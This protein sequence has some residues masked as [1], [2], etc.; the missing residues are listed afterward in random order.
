MSARVLLA[1]VTVTPTKPLTP[2]HVKG[3]LWLDVMYRATRLCADVDFQ[4]SLSTY[5]ATAQTLGFWEYLD[6]VHPEVDYRDH[7][8]ADI[9]A[10]Y[11]RY[12][13]DGFR[14]PFAALRPYLAAVEATGWVHPA[15]ARLV[16][17]WRGHYAHLG[18]HDPGLGDFR[19]PP[20]GHEETIERLCA[21]GICLDGRRQ[22]GAVY[23]DLTRFGQPLRRI[24]TA[25]DQANYLL[26]ALRELVGKVEAYDEIVLIHDR[27]L[28]EDFELLRRAVDA[29]GGS[30]VRVAVDRVPIDG[31][32]KSSRHGGW[33]GATLPAILADCPADDP[34]A[35]RLGLRVY[36]L[37]Q[38]GKDRTQS[39]RADLLRGALK[40]A[41]K[42]LGAAQPSLVDVAG[43]VAGHRGENRHV[44]PY[45]LTSGLLAKHRNPPVRAVAEAVYC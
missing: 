8:E 29:L 12:Q 21:R 33:E 11:V 14:A 2:S 18:M 30:A 40:R 9:G 38:L 17:I 34:A 24:A 7:D 45:R 20:M 22:G 15:S 13:A 10:L 26:L 42:L 39:F 35:L 5:N 41:R 3:L 25:D 28:T 27:E 4:Y 36:F 23:L 19:P 6:R 1:P 31:V 32:V 37:A 43:F 44:D 16:E